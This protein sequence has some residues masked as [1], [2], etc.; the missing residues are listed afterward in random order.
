ME[1]RLM[2][3]V[4]ESHDERLWVEPYAEA[5]LR[6]KVRSAQRSQGTKIARSHGAGRIVLIVLLAG[7]MAGGVIA[8][9]S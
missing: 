2:A 4:K 8:L 3:K 6:R 9:V 1:P 5:A 7:L